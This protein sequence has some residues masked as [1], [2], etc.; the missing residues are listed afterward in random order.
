MCTCLKSQ[1]SIVDTYLE[2]R[3]FGFEIFPELPHFSDAGARPTFVHCTLF[4]AIKPQAVLLEVFAGS[5]GRRGAEI[6]LRQG[7]R[8]TRVGG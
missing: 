1:P 6:I 4:L 3:V 5:N 7:N 2:G 8:E